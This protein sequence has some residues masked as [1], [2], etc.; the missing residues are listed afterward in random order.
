MTNIEMSQKLRN[1]LEV[2]GN[3]ETYIETERY[4]RAI[5]ATWVI[6][7]SIEILLKELDGTYNG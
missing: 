6:Q 7:D 3:C 5:D 2:A 1:I 4:D